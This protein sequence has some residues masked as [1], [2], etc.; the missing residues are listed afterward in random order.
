LGLSIGLDQS[1]LFFQGWATLAGVGTGNGSSTAAMQDAAQANALLTMRPDEN[2]GCLFATYDYIA[3]SFGTDTGPFGGSAPSTTVQSA[4]GGWYPIPTVGEGTGNFGSSA[5]FEPGLLAQNN[6]AIANAQYGNRFTNDGNVPWIVVTTPAPGW[7]AVTYNDFFA[8]AD[9]VVRRGMSA[10][11]PVGSGSTSGSGGAPAIAASTSGVPSGIPLKPTVDYTLSTPAPST[12]TNEY[13][14]RPIMLNRPFRSVADLD[15]VFSGTPWRSVD[16]STP[17]SGFAPLLD[18]FCINDTDD[19]NG[20]VAGKV[21]LNTRQPLVL[22]AILNGAY[23][24]EFNPSGTGNSAPLNSTYATNIAQALYNR[25]QSTAGNGL[26]PLTNLSELVGKWNASST[27]NCSPSING[28]SSYIGF[29]SD[30]VNSTGTTNTSMFDLTQA[31]VLSGSGSGATADVKTRVERFRDASI[32]A[33]ANCGQTRVW[34]LMIDI[35]AQ[36]GRFPSTATSLQNFNVE[37]EKRYWVHVAI[38]RYTGQVIDQQ[39]EEVKE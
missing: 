37:G 24:D 38:D 31:L 22:Q 18:V 12:T 5:V 11:V 3:N 20:L 32:R 15:Y 7:P 16:M 26:G 29:T 17:E 1:N 14:S 6:P 4:Y 23:T 2:R 27:T 8:D 21:D 9:G 10:Y 30:T 39:V 35:I 13:Q 28:G 34:N 33:L 36:T 25:T 19:Q